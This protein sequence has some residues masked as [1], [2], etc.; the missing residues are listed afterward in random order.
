[1]I[2]L[3]KQRPPDGHNM[4]QEHGKKE[5]TEPL[6]DVQGTSGSCASTIGIRLF[7]LLMDLA[8]EEKQI[9]FQLPW[10]NLRG[11]C[12]SSF[13]QQV[14]INEVQYCGYMPEAYSP[15]TEPICHQ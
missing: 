3:P 15:G 8:R 7:S 4:E 14:R 11:H 9:V 2:A 10:S 13:N 5:E 12:S 6:T 1:M